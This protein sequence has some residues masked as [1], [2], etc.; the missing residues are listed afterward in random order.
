MNII[1]SS[2]LAPTIQR[3]LTLN[4]TLGRLY[5]NE[6]R[7]LCSL[8]QF[9]ADPGN[10]YQDLSPESFLQWCQTQ[11][12]LT[13][14]VRRSQIRIVRNLCLY[15]RRTE[16]DCFVPDRLLFPAPHQ[17][18][19]PYIFSESETARLLAACS[20][21][22]RVN[23]SP[24]RPEVIR[25][26]LVLLYTTGPRRGEL[27]RLTVGDYDSQQGTLLIRAS[28][29]HKSRLLPLRPDVIQ[30]VE[31]YFQ[32]RRQHH[33]T[34]APETPL[35]WNRIGGG[36]AYTGP[37]LRESLAI[38]LN[39]CSIRTP[40]GRLPRIHD[41]RHSLAVNALLRWYRQGADLE[42]KL[43]LLATYLGHVSIFSTHYYLHFIEPLRTLASR[44]FADQY[45]GLV[46]PLA[47]GKAVRP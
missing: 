26:A 12:R 25:L 35:I 13:A 10:G 38:L 23:S 40:Q 15:R 9:L 18:I 33:L 6:E 37:G 34:M 1:L 28:K 11:E 39:R 24:L 16:P 8:D 41:W 36:R 47:A 42:A 32:I 44:R 30:E 4:R 22:P 20:H 14:T 31:H 2:A 21:L 7:V 43:P 17:P 29:F 46:R 45:A 19:K 27:L 3:Y 5:T